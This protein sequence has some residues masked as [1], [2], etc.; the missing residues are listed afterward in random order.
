MFQLYLVRSVRFRQ[1]V[2]ARTPDKNYIT[3]P[4]DCPLTFHLVSNDNTRSYTIDCF[5]NILQLYG[6]GSRLHS[7]YIRLSLFAH[8]VSQH[9]TS[10][11]KWCQ[12]I[13]YVT[14]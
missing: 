2:V 14:L 9:V 12:I 13:V 10:A 7:T 5:P 1:L 4:R 8:P 6:D 11:S 3:I